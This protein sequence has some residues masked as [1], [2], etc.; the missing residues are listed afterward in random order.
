MS[1]PKQTSKRSCRRKAVTTLGVAGLLS[2][3]GG[4]SAANVG[5]AADIPT[6]KTS[7]VIALS[8]EEI[9][10]ISLATFYV[11]DKENAGAHYPGVQLAARG[12]G[13][14]CGQWLRRRRGGAEAAGAAAGAGAAGCAVQRLQRMRRLRLRLRRRLLYLDC[15]CPDLLGTPPTFGM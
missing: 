13:H 5:P 15:R 6:A 12:C 8:E 11:F 9:S 4:A 1:R 14:G 7:P 10:D 3:A 2:L